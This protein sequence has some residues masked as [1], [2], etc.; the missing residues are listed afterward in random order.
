MSNIPK[1]IVHE[2]GVLKK[3]QDKYRE[4]LSKLNS[5][6]SDGLAVEEATKEEVIEFIAEM[7]QK[8]DEVVYIMEGENDS[9]WIT[10]I[11]NLKWFLI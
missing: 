5:L 1:W 9:E 2:Y 10:T 4:A 7:K 8:I 6:Q 3:E 11:K